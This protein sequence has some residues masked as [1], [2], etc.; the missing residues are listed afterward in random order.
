VFFCTRPLHH[1]RVSNPDHA[2][3]LSDFKTSSAQ[4]S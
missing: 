4:K 2:E 3:V 1:R